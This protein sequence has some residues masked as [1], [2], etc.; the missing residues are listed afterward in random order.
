MLQKTKRNAVRLFN[1]IAKKELQPIHFKHHK[2]DNTV[3]IS[4]SCKRSAPIHAGCTNLTAYLLPFKL[5][6]LLLF[7]FFFK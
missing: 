7:I 6:Q 3:S 2:K 4:D 5:I 1:C